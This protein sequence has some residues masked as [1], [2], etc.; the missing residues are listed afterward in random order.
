M[1]KL[2]EKIEI[3]TAN[4]YEIGRIVDTTNQSIIASVASVEIV[5]EQNE[6]VSG[7]TA[8]E[9]YRIIILDIQSEGEC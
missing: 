4:T 2:S 6:A 8:S 9:I 1:D 7:I 5:Q 3:V